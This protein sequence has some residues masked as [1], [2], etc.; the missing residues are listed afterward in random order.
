MYANIVIN[1]TYI[2]LYLSKAIY[3]FPF[4]RIYLFASL[5]IRALCILTSE[6][7]QTSPDIHP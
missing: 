4:L 5:S 3:I 2:L 6:I 1:A 7:S